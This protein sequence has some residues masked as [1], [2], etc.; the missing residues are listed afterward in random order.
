MPQVLSFSSTQK[1]RA[2]RDKNDGCICDVVKHEPLVNVLS[3]TS[4]S[5]I[6]TPC[7][8]NPDKM[9]AEPLG[10]ATCPAPPFCTAP[11]THARHAILSKLQL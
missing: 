10:Q 11:A 6:D 2:Q 9:K 4:K 3:Y 7:G 8:E 1:V 5:K